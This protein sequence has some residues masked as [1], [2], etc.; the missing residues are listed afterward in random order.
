M[1]SEDHLAIQVIEAA[2]LTPAHIVRWQE[3]R[4]ANPALWSPFFDHRYVQL[5]A[6][7]APGARVAVVCRA[8]HVVGFL[9]FQGNAGGLIRPLGA[10]LADQHGVIAAPD[11]PDIDAVMA[12]LPNATYRFTGLVSS[13]L[14]GRVQEYHE[15]FLADLSDGVAAYDTS[16][17]KA[18]PDH[19]KK[20]SRRLRK[21]ERDF[22]Q[23]RIESGVRDPALLSTLIEWKRKKY[24]ATGRHDILGVPWIAGF[25]KALLDSDAPDFGGEIAAMWL[26]DELAAVEFGMRSGDVL[27]SWFPSYEPKFSSVSPGVALMDAM[28]L[29]A[30]E[31]GI[32]LVDLGAGHSEYK[33]Y[34]SNRSVEI[35]DGSIEGAGPRRWLTGPVDRLGQWLEGAKLGEV[36]NLPGKFARRMEMILASE[37]TLAGRVRGI[38]WAAQDMAQRSG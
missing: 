31:R 21:A 1:T 32:R 26:G 24:R 28:I 4:A 5:A 14:S 34:V 37:P 35:T 19:F 13:S 30:G 15:V 23:V 17:I 12:L 22:G 18:W 3:L 16:R 8:G 7:F 25:I 10:P 38:V 29:Q 20:A 9:P 2:A 27:H 36:S 33:K 6:R 11:G